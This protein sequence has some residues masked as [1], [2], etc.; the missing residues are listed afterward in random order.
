MIDRHVVPASFGSREEQDSPSP[1]TNVYR[2]AN[3]A[4]VPGRHIVQRR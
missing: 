4:Q 2:C 1:A 3:I